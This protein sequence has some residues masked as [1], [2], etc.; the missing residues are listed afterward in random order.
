MGRYWFEVLLKWFP[1][2][3]MGCFVPTLFGIYLSAGFI[4]KLTGVTGLALLEFCVLEDSKSLGSESEKLTLFL[5]FLFISRKQ[6]GEE[7]SMDFGLAPLKE[8]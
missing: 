7:F 3:R 4:G 2:M 1:V 6:L 8:L 5:G